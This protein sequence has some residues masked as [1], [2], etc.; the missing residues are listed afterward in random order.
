MKQHFLK[1]YSGFN[2]IIL[3][4]VMFFIG[5]NFLYAQ[6]NDPLYI[7]SAGN[8]YIKVKNGNKLSVEG[9]AVFSDTVSVGVLKAVTGILP[10]RM[11]ANRRN[12]IA[13]PVAGLF[14]WCS[15]CGHGEAQVFNGSSWTNMMGGPTSP[16]IEIA[17]GQKLEGGIVAYIFQPGE[18]GYDDD[19]THGLIAAQNDQSIKAAWGCY[20]TR[21]PTN[22]AI[23][24]GYANTK[25]IVK[26]CDEGEIAA[27]ICDDLVLEGYS[28]WYLPSKD[29][30]NKLYINKDAIGGFDTRHV[31]WSSTEI[32]ELD[33]WSQDFG[34]NNW[35]LTP[36][37]QGNYPKYYTP[38]VRAVRTF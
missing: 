9:N 7:D 29:E 16:A 10:P 32:N 15:N 14:I 36:G 19:M 30:L 31:Y 24:T 4:P 38:C 23:G 27:K 35:G 2:K 13:N 33:A 25:N 37:F 1:I 17:I 34:N 26:A 18:P 8:V 20:G 3:V 28:D 21:I 6:N 22:S 12:S 11:S 5:S